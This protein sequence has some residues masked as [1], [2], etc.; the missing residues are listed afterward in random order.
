[1]KTQSPEF[2]KGLQIAIWIHSIVFFVGIFYAFFQWIF[3]EETEPHVFNMVSISVSDE[4]QINREALK[5]PVEKPSFQK[6]VQEKQNPLNTPP[7]PKPKPVVKPKPKPVVEPQPKPKPVVKSK[8]KPAAIP[9]LQPKPKV[10]KT[11]KPTQP[12]MSY[13]EYLKNNPIKPSKPIPPKASPS[14]TSYASANL[15]TRIPTIDSG[16]YKIEIPQSNRPVSSAVKPSVSE[17]NQFSSYVSRIID[18]RWRSNASK[19]VQKG[20][21]SIVS[22]RIESDGRITF[23]R[24]HRSSGNASFDN[25]TLATVRNIGAFRQKPPGGRAQNFKQAFE[26][27]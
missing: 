13:A 8:P 25:K 22:F 2:Q 11:P 12:K 5:S 27:K 14:P 9:K 19:N 24:L 23:V 21:L 6:P 3:E 17:L 1:M 20:W 16:D 18:A 15:P 10:K 4:N 7:K 26:S